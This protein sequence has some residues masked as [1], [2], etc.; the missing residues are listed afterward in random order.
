MVFIVWYSGIT[1]ASEELQK[2]NHFIHPAA[3]YQ[4]KTHTTIQ[5]LLLKNK[6]NKSIE[7][8]TNVFIDDLEDTLNKT[9]NKDF[10]LDTKKEL[11][12]SDTFIVDYL[13]NNLKLAVNNQKVS[14]NYI[15]KEYNGDIVFFYLEI[16]NISHLKSIDIKNML[17]LKY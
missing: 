17:L 3:N 12:N 4:Y 14:Y 10:R 2:T 15:G 6:E 1:K 11:E 8:I 16:E 13:K 9:Y 5:L 7:I